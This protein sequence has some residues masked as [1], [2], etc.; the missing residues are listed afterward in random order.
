MYSIAGAIDW[1]LAYAG[2]HFESEALATLA[3]VSVAFLVAG[4]MLMCSTQDQG[5]ADSN[6][7]G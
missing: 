6:T 2:H 4:Y 3:V 1:C 7:R 5:D